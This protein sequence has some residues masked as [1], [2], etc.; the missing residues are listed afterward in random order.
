MGGLRRGFFVGNFFKILKVLRGMP[1]PACARARAGA[2]APEKELFFAGGARNF[3]PPPHP[4]SII[5]GSPSFAP[6]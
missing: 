4:L 1:A 5:Y 3:S 6:P 2:N